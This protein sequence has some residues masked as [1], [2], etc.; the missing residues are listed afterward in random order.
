[1]LGYLSVEKVNLTGYIRLRFHKSS[2]NKELIN[3][4][5]SIFKDYVKT[6]PKF[7]GSMVFIQMTHSVFKCYFKVSPIQLGYSRVEIYT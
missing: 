2:V 5:Y 4:L 1:M 6:K 7:M 3:H